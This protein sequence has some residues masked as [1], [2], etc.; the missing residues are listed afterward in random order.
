M[1]T[2]WHMH[3]WTDHEVKST[4]SLMNEGTIFCLPDLIIASS[5]NVLINLKVD[6]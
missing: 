6:S 3:Q 4:H 2:V 5:E 1:W